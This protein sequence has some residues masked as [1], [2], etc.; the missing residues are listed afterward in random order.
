LKVFQDVFVHLVYNSALFF[1][2]HRC[3][4]LLNLLANLICIFLVSCQLVLLF[5][6]FQNFLIPFVVKK[7][8]PPPS[9]LKN[10]SL[11]DVSNFYPFFLR[12]QISIP[13]KRMGRDSAL[14]T[15]F[16]KISG[17]KLV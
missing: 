13:Y 2:S 14:Y 10:L 5:K 1:A 4:F 12:V 8:V 17:P 6:F 15:L 7:G 11:I 9:L 16:L 3:S